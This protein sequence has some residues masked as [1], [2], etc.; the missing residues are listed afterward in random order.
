MPLP[1]NRVVLN[2]LAEVDLFAVLAPADASS[3]LC[4]F[5]HDQVLT[6]SLLRRFLQEN[7]YVFHHNRDYFGLIPSHQVVYLVRALETLRQKDLENAECIYEESLHCLSLFWVSF[8][9]MLSRSLRT[10]MFQISI[11]TENLR[12]PNIL[13]RGL[14]GTTLIG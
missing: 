14:V 11:G 1:L 9:S 7:Q 10:F 13:L 4:K 5:I 6:I 8:L 12:L 3:M 2:R